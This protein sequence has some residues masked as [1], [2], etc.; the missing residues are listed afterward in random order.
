MC[1]QEFPFSR[2][3][4]EYVAREYKIVKGCGKRGGGFVFDTHTVHKVSSKSTLV[5]YLLSHQSSKKYKKYKKVLKKCSHVV[6]AHTHT[7]SR[8]PPSQPSLVFTRTFTHSTHIHTL[9]LARTHAPAHTH[10]GNSARE[11][12]ANDGNCRVPQLEQMSSCQGSRTPHPLPLWRSVHDLPRAAHGRLSSDKREA[13]SSMVLVG[14][15]G[16]ARRCS[17]HTV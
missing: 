9:L 17:A 8:S 15:G 13:L 2:F 10:A 12:D 6:L 11:Q 3:R 1:T 14:S 7:L 16:S 5:L 4:D